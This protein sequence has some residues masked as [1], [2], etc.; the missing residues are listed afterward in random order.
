MR[1]LGAEKDTENK[2]T[3]AEAN[4]AANV[5]EQGATVAPE[6]ASSKKRATRKTGAPTGHKKAKGGKGKP[7]APQKA[8]KSG[9]KAGKGKAA[10]ATPPRAESKGAKI[11]AMIRRPKGATLTD[12]MKAT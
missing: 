3:N 11:L 4:T 10:K 7:A 8:A 9:K 1:Q 5:A 6:Q 2:M 12:I